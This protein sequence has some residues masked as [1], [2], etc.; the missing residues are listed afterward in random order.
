M[1][2]TDGDSN[3]DVA[4]HLRTWLLAIGSGLLAGV[5][6]LGFVGLMAVW[7]VGKVLGR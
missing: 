3:L 5:C 1:R 2:D 4:G 6:T 7:L